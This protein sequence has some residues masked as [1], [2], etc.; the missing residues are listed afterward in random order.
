[1]KLLLLIS[2]GGYAMRRSVRSAIA[3][4]APF[5]ELRMLAPDAEAKALK[6]CGVTT[7]TWR[8]AGLFNVLRSISALRR[9]VERYEPDAIHAFGW[10]AAA[11]SLG[12]LPSRYASRTLVTLQDPIRKNEMPKSFLDKRLPELLARAGAIA[13][14]YETLRRVIV[15]SFAVPGENVSVV[16]YGVKPLVAENLARAPG[17]RGP[18]IGY[19]GR[20][21]GDRAWETAV[22]AIAD[23]VQ[24]YPDAQLWLARTGPIASLVRAHARSKGVLNSVTFFDD[25]PLSELFSGV[26]LLVV[27]GTH[28]GLPYALLEA[29]VSGIPVV[30]ANTGGIADTLRPYSGFL[31]P[32]DS[33]G[34]ATGI[35]EAWISIDAA[36]VQA[37]A[38]R[39]IATAAFDPIAI[40][41]RTLSTYTRLADVLE[42]RENSIPPIEMTT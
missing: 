36:W 8:P 10:T 27:P 23:V 12:A 19:S 14:A 4:A 31:V 34:F 6:D 5:H 11:V 2:A 9:A 28:D 30:G 41:R 37:Q 3:D 16:P 29:L 22:D 13:C 25:L 24:T 21:E 40:T 42:S 33:A 39:P 17:R 7:E 1:M 18:I 20:L 38:Q 32:D 35:T 26:D 15:D